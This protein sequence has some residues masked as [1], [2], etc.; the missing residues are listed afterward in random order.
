MDYSKILISPVVTEK[1]VAAQTAK[2]YSFMVKLDANKIEIAKAVESAY[3]VNVLDVNI[4]T[5]RKKVRKAGKG[6]TITK[7]RQGKRAIVTIQAKQ[8]IDFNKIK[9]A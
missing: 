9:S 2:K 7:R 3:G 5:I 6:R 1:S 4:V 8:T